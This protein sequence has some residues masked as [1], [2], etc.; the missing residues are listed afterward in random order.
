LAITETI[1]GLVELDEG[2]AGVMMMLV[3]LISNEDGKTEYDPFTIYFVYIVLE[4]LVMM[5]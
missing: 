1:Y 3:I 2:L 5:I 4:A